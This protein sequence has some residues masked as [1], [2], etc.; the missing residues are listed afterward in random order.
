MLLDRSWFDKDELEISK[1]YGLLGS[2]VTMINYKFS[3]CV[4]ISV[5]DEKNTRRGQVMLNFSEFF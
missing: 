1:P 5:E 4:Y 3:I 2:Q